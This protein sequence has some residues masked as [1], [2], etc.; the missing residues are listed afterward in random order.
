MTVLEKNN[1]NIYDF[2]W[3]K[4][5]RNTLDD[6]GFSYIWNVNDLDNNSIKLFFRQRC[7]DI[8]WQNWMNDVSTNGQCTFY[9]MFKEKTQ[10]EKYL[11]QLEE[12]NNYNLLKFRTRTH[13]YR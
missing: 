9:N 4:H 11:I 12:P 1:P 3:I 7:S 8:F 5:I 13:F 2:K 6:T 10:M